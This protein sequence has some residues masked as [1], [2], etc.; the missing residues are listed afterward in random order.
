MKIQDHGMSF[1]LYLF[2][3]ISVSNIRK[4][5]CETD[6]FLYAVHPSVFLNTI[7]FATKTSHKMKQ[8]K[9]DWQYSTA[10]E[11]LQ[12][13]L[14]E[15]EIDPTNCDLNRL[16]KDNLNIFG[17]YKQHNFCDKARNL[18]KR[19]QEKHRPPT[20]TPK[21]TQIMNWPSDGKC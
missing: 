15:G 13:K 21:K 12:Q 4:H 7:T 1:L 9:S 11:W 2:T 5:T 17:N 8:K 6:M 3:G 19:F 14:E 20:V 18:I 10:K 16:Y